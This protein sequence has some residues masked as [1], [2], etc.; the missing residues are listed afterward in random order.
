M[1]HSWSMGSLMWWCLFVPKNSQSRPMYNIT[2]FAKMWWKR[3]PHACV[4]FCS[5]SVVYSQRLWPGHWR[6][7]GRCLSTRRQ[8]EQ[9]IPPLESPVHPWSPRWTFV[10]AMEVFQKRQHQT[11]DER[12]RTLKIWSS[13]D[14]PLSACS[15][16]AKISSAP[17][18]HIF[19]Q[20]L[21][22]EALSEPGLCPCNLC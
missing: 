8:K 19:I 7:P 9:E 1:S 15:G 13:L 12:P 16:F 17:C 3:R 20:N 4:L 14:P 10:A 21:A 6:A 2:W 18:R 22:Q 5:Y 11:T